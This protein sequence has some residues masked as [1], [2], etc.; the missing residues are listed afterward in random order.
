MWIGG[1][2]IFFGVFLVG[3]LLVVM[4]DLLDLGE[5]VHYMCLGFC[6]KYFVLGGLVLCMMIAIDHLLVGLFLVCL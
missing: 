2:S 1:F 3:S 5:V 4:Y 6:Q